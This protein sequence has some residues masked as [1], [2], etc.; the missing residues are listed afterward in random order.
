MTDAP[1]VSERLITEMLEHRKKKF[2]TYSMEPDP[3]AVAAA[4]T[5]QAF[6]AR[7]NSVLASIA[8]EMR[9][10]TK[11]FD[12]KRNLLKT[13]AEVLACLAKDG[14]G[15]VTVEPTKEREHLFE[16]D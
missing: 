4:N 7:T 10:G 16:P 1:K 2:K 5:P 14:P 11:H 9:L 3:E 13:P 6:V 8:E 12:R 15:A